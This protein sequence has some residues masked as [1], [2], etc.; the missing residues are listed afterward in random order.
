MHT[1]TPIYASSQYFMH[2]SLLNPKQ[3]DVCRYDAKDKTS[4][5]SLMIK[6]DLNAELIQDLRKMYKQPHRDVLSQKFAVQ[7]TVQHAPQVLT[8]IQGEHFAS[9]AVWEMGFE[10]KTISLTFYHLLPRVKNVRQKV[11]WRVLKSSILFALYK[12][13]VKRVIP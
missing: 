11:L 2:I 13:K 12:Q 1:C 5:C 7:C 8:L 4:V 3:S 6:L 10:R 9:L